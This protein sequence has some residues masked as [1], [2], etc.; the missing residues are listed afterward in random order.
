MACSGS[1]DSLNISDPPVAERSTPSKRG[2]APAVWEA[3]TS[4]FLF[5][6]GMSPIT[7]D[8]WRYSITER[9]WSELVSTTTPAARCHHTLISDENNITSLMFG[10]FSNSG[11]FNDLWQFDHTNNQWQKLSPTGVLPIKRCLHMAVAIETTQKMLIYGGINGGG[12]NESD[13]FGDTFLYDIVN[14]SWEEIIGQGPGRRSGSVGFFSPSENAVYLWGGKDVNN[15][16]NDLWRFDMQNL[17]WQAL[18]TSGDL[19]Q[20]RE[21]PIYYF[22]QTEN[23]FLIFSGRND[24]APGNKLL[25]D[26][27]EL[28]LSDM[29][30]TKITI[31]NSPSPRWRA[32][33]SFDN[34]KGVGYMFGGWQ[35]FGGASAFNDNWQFDYAERKWSLIE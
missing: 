27:F 25:N 6:G 24:N 32:S 35:D 4:S 11:R 34:I 30:W 12:N 23:T 10:G 18:D 16:P 33:L 2:G 29:T 21:D 3:A 19:P 22:N 31:E 15:F 17:T 13:F 28:S 1:D 20:G 5:F 26:T 8:T 14:N 7:D 9:T